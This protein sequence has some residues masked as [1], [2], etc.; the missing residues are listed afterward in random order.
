[1]ANNEDKPGK[2]DDKDISEVQNTADIPAYLMGKPDDEEM[3]LD[4]ALSKQ[5]RK[6]T[7]PLDEKKK[8]Q[9]IYGAV[10]MAA[11]LLVLA[12]FSCQPAKGSM[13][14]GICSTFLELNSEYPHTIHHVDLEGS[15]TAVRIYFTSTDPF[16]EYK[17]EMIECTFGPDEAMGMKLT[18][19]TRNRRPVDPA[20]VKKFN[21]TLPTIM[22]SEPYVTLPPAWKN[23]LLP[24]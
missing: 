15:M 10:A 2:P 23:P 18:Q 9:I 14:Y 8:K 17:L 7:K 21:I 12:V 5:A 22:A 19:V 24:D 1:M 4:A 6:K 13:A 20:I 11:V 16:G 3:S